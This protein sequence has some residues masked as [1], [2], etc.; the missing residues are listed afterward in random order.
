MGAI[1]LA[2]ALLNATL[3]FYQGQKSAAILKSFLNM[4]PSKC[5]LIRNGRAEE[6]STPSVVL[7]DVVHI[8]MGDKVPAD[9]YMFYV[10]AD[11]L[12]VDN[13]SLTGESEPQDRV[14]TNTHANPL[15]ATNLA[16]YGTL[17]SEGDG[18]GIAIRTGDNTVLGQIAGL[19]ARE[20]KKASP[21]NQEINQF[22]IQMAVLATIA[23]IIF[24]IIGM[25]TNGNVSMNITFAIGIFVAFVP[26]GLP[27]TVTMLLSIAAGKLAKRNILVKDLQGVE[28]LGAIVYCY[29]GVL[30]S[31]LHRPSLPPTK[32]ARSR[33]IRWL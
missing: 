13:S 12:K 19:T 6:A 16:F 9:L 14:A 24:F 30:T 8:K 7:G 27:A 1:L 5:T 18:Y 22:V 10:G 21:L 3:E 32:R 4:V 31:P 11:G 2:V 33:G 25:R 28:T 23:A 17:V 15:E 26:Q 29:R 20:T